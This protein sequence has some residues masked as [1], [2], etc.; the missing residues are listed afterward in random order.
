MSDIFDSGGREFFR[1]GNLLMTGT[2]ACTPVPNHAWAADEL[3]AEASAFACRAPHPRDQARFR[4]LPDKADGAPALRRTLEAG[5]ARPF[6]ALSATDREL[7]LRRAGEDDVFA[8][9]PRRRGGGPLPMIAGLYSDT[10]MGASRP[11]SATLKEIAASLEA[12]P[13]YRNSLIVLA[14]DHASAACLERFGLRARR[15]FHDAPDDVKRDAVHKMKHWMCLWALRE[16]GEFLWVDWD[17]VVIK[18][19]DENFWAKCRELGTPKFIWIPNY[20]ATVNCGV[21]CANIDWAGAMERGFMARVSEPNDELL[22]AAVLPPEVRERDE[23]WWGDHVAHVWDECD[24]AA[25]TASTYFAHVRR[26]SW[27]EKLRAVAAT[28]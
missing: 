8:G 16:F 4:K 15:V 13:M 18:P 7:A 26:I 27:A 19:P 22:W 10:R 11:P 5:A 20:W 28:R 1:R 24:F 23:F 21:Y 14:G 12:N 25:V 2:A 6:A 9:A 3:L 17:T